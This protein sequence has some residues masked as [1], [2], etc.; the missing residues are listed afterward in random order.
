MLASSELDLGIAYQI[1]GN[2]RGLQNFVQ[3][4]RFSMGLKFFYPFLSME[5]EREE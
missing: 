1:A 4:K 2:A 3:R 5:T